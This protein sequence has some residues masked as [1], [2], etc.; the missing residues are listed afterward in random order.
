[1]GFEADD[2]QGRAQLV[3]DVVEE[4]VA[5]VALRL[6]GGGHPVEGAAHLAQLVGRGDRQQGGVPALRDGAEGFGQGGDGGGDALGE[7]GR[8]QERDGDGQ[9]AADERGVEQAAHKVLRFGCAERLVE[10]EDGIPHRPPRAVAGDVDDL[11]SGRLR[12]SVGRGPGLKQFGEVVVEDV[13]V[14][15]VEEDA[16]F[17]FAGP[18]V[19]EDVVLPL[20]VTLYSD[21]VARRL[22]RRCACVCSCACACARARVG[23]RD[24][25]RLP[26]VRVGVGLAQLAGDK[27]GRFAA[28]LAAE[29]VQPVERRRSSRC[30]R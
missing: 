27:V 5:Q 7:P 30:R 18:F 28:E 12:V 16:D 20:R 10:V 17:V 25:Q 11:L 19:E 2:A 22:F 29:R 26:A 3:G 24:D 8:Q 9:E 4:T 6:Q 1:M 15:D 21:F 13:A 23:H 14:A